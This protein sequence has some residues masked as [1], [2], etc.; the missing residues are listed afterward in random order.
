MQLLTLNN[1]FVSYLYTEIFSTFQQLMK[2]GSLHFS[3]LVLGTKK[4]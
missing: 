3:A 4:V 2:N 1:I